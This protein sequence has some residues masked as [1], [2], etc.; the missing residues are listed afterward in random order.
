M[1]AFS[2]SFLLTVFVLV[3]TASFHVSHRFPFFLFD[4]S[5]ENKGFAYIVLD[6][7]GANIH[8]FGTHLQ[9]DSDRKNVETRNRA[10]DDLH[11]FIQD[12]NIPVD[13]LV[14]FAGDFNINKD[15][16]EFKSLLERLSASQPA[17]TKD[18]FGRGTCRQMDLLVPTVLTTHPSTSTMCSPIRITGR[19]SH[20]SRPLSKSNHLSML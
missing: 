1:N 7:Q 6:Y 3:L 9:S 16:K 13:E 14:I 11:S 17:V 5:L 18:I 10:L 20:L 8:V 15:T 4:I 19:S 12:R 2:V